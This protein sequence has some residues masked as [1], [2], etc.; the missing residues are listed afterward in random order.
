[1]NYFDNEYAVPIILGN[2]KETMKIAKI[3]RK[4]TSLDIHIFARRLSP[5]KRFQYKFHKITSNEDSIVLLAL[6]DFANNLHEYYTPILIYC[7]DHDNDFIGSHTL[8][9]ENLFIII[10]TQDIAKDIMGR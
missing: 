10:K 6:I 1:M 7:S 2:C 9:L 4:S 3:L 5:L 8:E